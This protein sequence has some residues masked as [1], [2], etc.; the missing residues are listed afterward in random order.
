LWPNSNHGDDRVHEVC[1]SRP[2]SAEPWIKL[3][4]FVEL[5]RPEEEGGTV[6]STEVF[7]A[8]PAPP[9]EPWR[10]RNRDQPCRRTH[11]T[12][13]SPTILVTRS[14]LAPGP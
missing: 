9:R 5:L 2:H 13:P 8:A 14:P 11:R 4:S 12:F 10:G 6:L 1:L 7:T 3:L